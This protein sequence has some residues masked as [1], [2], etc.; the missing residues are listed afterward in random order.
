MIS[1]SL[2]ALS[3]MGSKKGGLSP[4]GTKSIRIVRPFDANRFN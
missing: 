4:K 2:P 3:G 1:P